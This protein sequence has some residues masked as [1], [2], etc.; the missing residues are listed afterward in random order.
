[1]GNIV[2]VLTM[3][4]ECFPIRGS[5]RRSVFRGT[6]P[7]WENAMHHATAT[8]VAGSLLVSLALHIAFPTAHACRF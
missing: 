4:G 3:L 1:M 7:Q 5:A 2:G 6:F 8:R